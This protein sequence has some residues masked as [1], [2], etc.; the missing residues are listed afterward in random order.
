MESM[1]REMS[2]AIK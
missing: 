1:R 2:Q